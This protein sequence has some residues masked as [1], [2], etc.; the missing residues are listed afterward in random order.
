MVSIR[1][2]GKVHTNACTGAYLSAVSDGGSSCTNGPKNGSVRTVGSWDA[3]TI[4]TDS[5]TESYLSTSVSVG[6]SQR[7]QVTF[8]PYV[9]S[10][11]N[12]DI[13]IF[14]PG[15]LNAGDCD[16]RTSVDVEVFPFSGGLGWTSTISEQ[17]DY[18][19]KSLIYSGPVGATTDSFTPTISLALS[20]DP[21][22]PARG[23]TYTV[24]ADRVQLTFIG[25][26]GSVSSAPLLNN[27]TAPDGYVGSNGTTL[28]NSS[29]TT[30]SSYNVAF[31]VFEWSRSS[32]LNTNAASNALSN[33]TETALTRLGFA[34]DAALNAS[35]SSASSWAVNTIVAMD[36]TVFIGGDFSSTN[37]FTNVLSIDTSSGQTSALA[38][39]GLGGIVNTA[40]VID[41]YVF[42]GGDF[43]STA[44]S[45]GAALNY[46]A[47]YDPATKA[48]A[49]VGG[50][51]D[52]YVTDLMAS[53]SSTELFVM[54]N[55]SHVINNDGS[56]NETGGF[57]VWNIGSERWTSS[58]VVF[59]NI[60]AGEM[61]SS[62]SNAYLAGRVSGYADNAADGLAILSTDQS[63]SAKISSLTGASFSTTGSASS[64]T[65]SRRRSLDIKSSYTRSWLS[66]FAGGLVERALPGLATR[67]T[68]SVI[69]TPSFP[70]PAVLAVDYWANTSASDSSSIMILGGNF[71]SSNDADVQ[72]MAFYSTSQQTVD[73]PK[74]PV[75]GVVRALEVIGDRLYLG[76]EGVSVEG[77]G[78]GLL[79]YNL[80]NGTWME[81]GMAPLNSEYCIPRSAFLTDL[82]QLH[83]I[84]MQ[85][86][87]RFE[88]A[89]LPIHLLWL[90]VSLLQA[91]SLVRQSVY[92]TPLML[93]GRH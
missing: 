18:D 74:P 89:R 64:L 63:G 54:G 46:L 92:G 62:S 71:T 85:L 83:L 3:T 52:G 69:A 61:V 34:L 36:S 55:F 15:C 60:S 66:R 65:T 76:G 68:A 43:T 25:I 79:V 72:G 38:S 2:H 9:S 12:Y 90:V 75:F 6:D 5:A 14:I 86:S 78:S 57:G 27:G 23:H 84:P 22:K 56:L 35:G 67:A 8:Y 26:D 7:P 21:Y 37:N 40:V 49:A 88:P 87:T 42:F 31:G 82:Y 1:R 77:I 33:V 24:V 19:T 13:Y 58:G 70:A 29:R 47:R 44:S 80:L 11:G 73:G 93:S 48:W 50:G 28:G 20:S 51:V 10:A 4:A 45:G 41:G 16:S 59:G 81:G 17:V 53:P 39:Q 30:N 91:L 32:K